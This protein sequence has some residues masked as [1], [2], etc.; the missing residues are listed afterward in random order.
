MWNGL[1]PTITHTRVCYWQV[2]PPAGTSMERCGSSTS[3]HATDQ[4]RA[5]SL[6][7]CRVCKPWQ[8]YPTSCCQIVPSFSALWV[9]DIC[10]S[11][12]EHHLFT[13]E[14]IKGVVKLLNR[15]RESIMPHWAEVN[16][17]TL[18]NTPQD[19]GEVWPL[20]LCT[21]SSTGS[22]LKRDKFTP[23]KKWGY[24]FIPETYSTVILVLSQL[25]VFIRW[26]ILCNKSMA[27]NRSLEIQFSF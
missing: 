10:C 17:D 12:C 18:T 27:Q 5:I 24:Q 23:L 3:R 14:T 20:H 21:V 1:E 26:V 16:S 4:H 2:S 25:S 7:L 9:K 13:Q 22:C 8:H 15:V 6:F 19:H 11:W